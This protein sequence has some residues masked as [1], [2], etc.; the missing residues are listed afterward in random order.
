MAREIA[1]AAGALDSDE[2]FPSFEQSWQGL[3]IPR[4]TVEVTAQVR[5]VGALLH[6]VT[7]PDPE[8]QV[9]VARSILSGQD[10][11]DT[12]QPLLVGADLVVALFDEDVERALRRARQLH[13]MDPEVHA[14]IVKAVTTQSV[15]RERTTA[16]GLLPE[17]FGP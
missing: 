7:S 8:R 13:A 5:V 15:L 16:L 3:G 1:R 4:S 12:D 17:D 14:S 9:A 10:L 2:A 6:A 11:D